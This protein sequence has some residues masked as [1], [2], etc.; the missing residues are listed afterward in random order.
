MLSNFFIGFDTPSIFDLEGMNKRNK[1]FEKHLKK[2][3][4]FLKHWAEDF[5][6]FPL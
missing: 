1:K 2:Q 6:L 4:N 5:D 3:S